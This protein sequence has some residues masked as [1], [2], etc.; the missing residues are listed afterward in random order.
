MKNNK[1]NIKHKEIYKIIVDAAYS[2][3]IFNVFSDFIELMALE[4]AIGIGVES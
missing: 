3:N 1:A 4:M 2:K